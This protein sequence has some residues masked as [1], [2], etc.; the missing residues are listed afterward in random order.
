MVFA[1]NDFPKHWVSTTKGH[2]CGDAV[3]FVVAG[4]LRYDLL[5]EL[6]RKSEDG[7]KWCV[8]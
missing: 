3:V 5:F 7:R 8:R 6:A 2:Q 1:W 4:E